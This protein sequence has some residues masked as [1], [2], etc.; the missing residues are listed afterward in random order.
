MV[1]VYEPWGK[2]RGLTTPYPLA[3]HLIDTAAAASALWA[4]HLP[5]GTRAWLA[6]ELDLTEHAT[7]HLITEI[8]A[9]HDL[10]KAAPGFQNQENPDSTHDFLAHDRA[11]YLALPTLLDTLPNGRLTRWTAYRIGELLGGH[12]GLFPTR[13]TD[14]RDIEQ[15]IHRIPELGGTPWHNTRRDLLNR[16]HHA[17]N[18]PAPT[19]NL[20]TYEAATIIT[21]IVCIADWLV[22]DTNWI[23]R[24]R[25]TAPTNLNRRFRHMEKHVG[26]LIADYGLTAPA[27]LGDHTVQST[28]GTPPNPMQRSIEQSFH[29][30]RAGITTILDTTGGGK[31]NTA[32]IAQH[33]Y[34][35]ATGRHGV[36]FGLP[37][38][39][40]ANSMW[41]RVKDYTERINADTPVTLAH[42]M[43]RFNTDY[44]AD[45]EA[46][47]WLNGPNKTLLAGF[48]VG[49][50][51]QALAAVLTRK[52][53]FLRMAG[54]AGKTLIVDEAHA[55]DPYMQALLQRLM[56]WCG[57]LNIPVVLLSAT[58]PHHL[59]A[60]LEQ[61]Y[62][63]GADLDPN[64]TEPPPYPG[65]TSIDTAGHRQRPTQHAA[66]TMRD[67]RP[68]T[69]HLDH[70]HV[71]PDEWEP[72]VTRLVRH[73]LDHGHGQIGIVC[74]TVDTAQRLYTALRD[75]LTTTRL[76]LLH[77]RF[78]QW[79]RGTI[80][81]TISAA[82]EPG[83]DRTTPRVVIGTQILQESLD[84]DF[85][86]LITDLAPIAQLL[87]RLGRVHR[88][89]N[90]RP[91]WATRPVLTVLN[92]VNTDRPDATL[93]VPW[94]F[95]Y[96]RYELITTARVLAHHPGTLT[97]PHDVNALVQQVHHHDA[98]PLDDADERKRRRRNTTAHR[99]NA[100]TRYITVPRPGRVSQLADLTDPHV[101][102]DD[103]ATRL[104]IDNGRIIPRFTSH[105]G[106]TW[107]DA[108]HT[109]PFPHTRPKPHQ[110]E[111]L[112]NASITAP[113]G[114]T[115]RL[116]PAPTTWHRAPAV[117]DAAILDA[118]RDRGLRLDPNLGLVK[119]T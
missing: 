99:D 73:A 96:D 118:P 13:P 80:T 18:G 31:T 22:S 50:I 8:A 85:D 46:W 17:L 91:A 35:H 61:S 88:H 10:C 11:A 42:S 93:P 84:Y 53:N 77:S 101:T 44:A 83:G 16:I 69:V 63:D 64:L 66:A 25:N 113:S 65:W 21:G 6:G 116:A 81:N 111:Q 54:L 27:T 108:E 49:T 74:N 37:T 92:P 97:M 38:Q 23:E 95:V 52:W 33:R 12:H 40:T 3:F 62:L 26:A 7:E 117:A 28:W 67:A 90:P 43:A 19:P 48:S 55:Y 51:D 89:T 24:H 45:A 57:R 71:T 75:T 70:K 109:I 58:L 104:G 60:G 1:D 29:P 79:Q 76:H 102:D 107:L 56:S 100:R 47:S 86:W 30:H 59:H 15:P 32:L 87:Q 103:V 9:G 106:N 112:I 2:S 105:D 119:E 98:P 82:L 41:L 20:L 39:A 14:M 72:R 36:F 110:V 94:T 114:H 68:R 5:P 4:L 34:G 115:Q 78:P